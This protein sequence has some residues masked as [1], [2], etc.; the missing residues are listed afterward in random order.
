MMKRAAQ[1]WSHRSAA[2]SS[3]SRDAR[4]DTPR[5]SSNEDHNVM[6]GK[7]TVALPLG[8]DSWSYQCLLDQRKR[9]NRLEYLVEWTPTWE[10]ADS[11]ADLEQAVINY[12]EMQ[13]RLDDNLDD[14]ED[15]YNCSLC[16]D[17]SDEYETGLR[18]VV[19]PWADKVLTVVATLIMIKM[20]CMRRM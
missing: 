1:T 11:I 9:G 4:A 2:F 18:F 5:P 19:F 20:F 6:A 13:R 12:E 15:V 3:P 10:D 16:S 8:I 14:A 17:A 7:K